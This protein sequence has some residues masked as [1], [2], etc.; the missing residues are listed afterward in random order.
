MRHLL[1]EITK[2]L[3]AEVFKK[4]EKKEREIE[5]WVGKRRFSFIDTE[6]S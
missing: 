5:T 4:T 3:L 1:R 6:V 2:V